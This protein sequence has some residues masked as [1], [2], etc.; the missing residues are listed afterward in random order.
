MINEEKKKKILSKLPDLGKLQN[1]IDT[2]QSKIQ[3]SQ[4]PDTLI[5]QYEMGDRTLVLLLYK[6]I[7]DD[8]LLSY[9]RWEVHA[10]ELQFPVSEATAG[11]MVAL[12]LA[13]K[14]EFEAQA[15][16]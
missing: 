3:E 12:Y 2:L 10:G 8:Q 7:E 11:L 1:T 15:S 16:R 6:K 13:Q 9:S 4:N 5:F 14:A